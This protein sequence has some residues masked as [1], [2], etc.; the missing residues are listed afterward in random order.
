MRPPTRS[1][2]C[3]S[4]DPP[5]AAR[6]PGLKAE[7]GLEGAPLQAGVGAAMVPGVAGVGVAALL[8]AVVAEALGLTALNG[9][10][11]STSSAKS[12]YKVCSC[13]WSSN[14]VC[15]FNANAACTFCIMSLDVQA[16]QA[17]LCQLEPG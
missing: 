4:S 13:R 1:V 14:S 5:G 8:A 9:W 6:P 11:S 16:M 10:T 12:G 3:A 17:D 15:C 7:A 2:T